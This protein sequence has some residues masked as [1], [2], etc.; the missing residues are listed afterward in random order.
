MVEEKNKKR[1]GILRGGMGDFYETSLKEG[2]DVI[3]YLIENLS[4]QLKPVDILIDKEGIWHL[5]GIP[6]SP[7]DLINKVDV[8]WNATHLSFSNIL[9]NFSIPNIGGLT[10]SLSSGNARSVLQNEIKN[11]GIRMPN[12]IVLPLYQEDFDGPREK[13]SIKK[14][15][16]IHAKF[17]S[18]WIVKSFTPDF[19]MGIHIANTFG[20]LV[21]AIE[22]GVKHKKS[23]LVEEFVEGKETS[24]HTVSNFRGSN[25]YAFPPLEKFSSNEKEKLINFSKNLHNHLGASS[26]LK[27]NFIL[28][29]KKGI[30][31]KNIELSPQLEDNSHFHESCESVG[32]KKDDVILHILENAQ[33]RE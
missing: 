13:Y 3:L 23:I 1:V 18:P 22:D 30:Y 16:E 28:D 14:A 10:H 25:V 7:S 11:I 24:M 26:Y 4:N 9:E 27:S 20:E 15:K 21:D 31:L 12:H 17:S 19:S 33:N 2:G 5:G 32:A 8:I 6:I 29:S